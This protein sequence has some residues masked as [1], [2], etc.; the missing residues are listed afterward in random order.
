MSKFKKKL[1][2]RILAYILSG[3]M[4]MSNMTA[5][6]TEAPADTREEYYEEVSEDSVPDTDDAET[7]ETAQVEANLTDDGE[8]DGEDSDTENPDKDSDT[9]NPDDKDSDMENPKPSSSANTEE[10]SNVSVSSDAPENTSSEASEDKETPDAD[11]FYNGLEAKTF[12]EG[13]PYYFDFTELSD[14][15]NSYT[16]GLFSFN[17]GS[18]NGATYENTIYGV[19]FK[20]GNKLTFPISGDSYLVVGG[21]NSNDCTDLAATSTPG[22]VTPETLTTI[23]ANHGTLKNCKERGDNTLVFEYSG[24]T[25]TITLT[26]DPT[27]QRTTETE[28]NHPSQ[29]EYIAYV[30]IIPKDYEKPGDKESTEMNQSETETETGSDVSS[31]SAS[32]ESQPETETGTD[33]SSESAPSGS[34]PESE[35]ETETGTDKSSESASSES[36]P[37]SESETETGTDKSS[38]SVPMESETESEVETGSDE[39]SENAPSESQTDPTPITYPVTYDFRDGSI[40]PADTSLNGTDTVKS[41][42]GALTVECGPS[43]GYGYN[44]SDHGSILKEGN[45]ITLH[46]PGSVK[47]FI[48]GCQYSGGSLVVTNGS[49]TVQTFT[50]SKTEACYHNDS[51]AGL[52]FEYEGEETDLVM[53]FGAGSTYVPVITVDKLPDPI[54]YPVTY[55]FRDGSI[56]PADTSLNGTDTVKSADGALTVECGPSNGYGYNGSEHGSILKE[57]NKIT[58]HVP[59][60]VKVFIGGCQYSGGSLVVT[61]GSETV[62]TFTTSKTEACYHNDSTAGLSFE[63]KGEETDLVMTFGAGSTY[64]P[65]I[66]VDRISGDEN[67]DDESSVSNESESTTETATTPETS[68]TKNSSDVTDLEEESLP[69]EEDAEDVK[70]KA[71][72]TAE[73]GIVYLNDIRKIKVEA[74]DLVVGSKPAYRVTVTYTNAN[75]KSQELTEGIHYT[76]ALSKNSPTNDTTGKTAGDYRIT[77]T[78]TDTKTDLGIFKGTKTVSYKMI[79]KKTV[80]KTKDITKVKGIGFEKDATKNLTY[81]GTYVT[82]AI[83]VPGLTEGTHY[84]VVYKNNVNAGKA[85]ATVIGKGEYYGQKEFKFT[86][87]P[88]NIAAKDV[89]MILEASNAAIS[90]GAKTYEATEKTQTSTALTYKGKAITLN[91]LTVKLPKEVIKTDKDLTLK[92]GIDYTVTY[93]KNTTAGTATAAIKG[94]NNFSGAINVNYTIKAE[95]ITAEQIM[96]ATVTAE[97]TTKGAVV[98]TITLEGGLTLKAGTDFKADNKGLKDTAVGETGKAV[99][100]GNGAYKK[101]FDKVEVSATVERGSFHIK[102]NAVVDITKGE[103]S[104]KLVAA[105]KITDASGAKVKATDVTVAK[106]GNTAIKVTPTSA[107]AAKFNETTLTCHV[108]KKLSSVAKAKKIDKNNS[109]AIQKFDGV[110]NVTLTTDQIVKIYLDANGVNADDIRI[111]SYK[112]NNKIGA[113]TVV[114]EGRNNSPYYGTMNVKFTIA[115]AKPTLGTGA[116]DAGT[117]ESFNYEEESSQV[118]ES[119]GTDGSDENPGTGETD[120][121]VDGVVKNAGGKPDVWDFAAGAVKVDGSG[122]PTEYIDTEKYNNMLTEDVINS[123]NIT[124]GINPGSSGGAIGSFDVKDKDGNVI[125]EFNGNGKTNNRLRTMNKKITRHDEKSLKDEN[126][127]EYLGYVYS[128]SSSEPNVYLGVMLDEGDI[129]TAI[130]GSN[131]GASTIKFEP[132]DGG[133]EAQTYEYKAENERIATFYAATTGEYKMYS[134]NEKLVVA[135]VTVEKTNAVTVSGAVQ[136]PASLT[137]AYAVAFKCRETGAV[138]TA[139]VEDGKYTVSLNEGYTYDVALENANGYIIT[140]ETPNFKLEMGKDT[141][142]YDINITNVSLVTVTGSV[143]GFS[144]VA[145]G[146]QNPIETLDLTFASDNIYVP[147][148]TLN[149][150]TGEFTLVLEKGVEYVVTADGVDDFTLKTEKI[151]ADADGTQDITFEAKSVYNVTIKPEGVTAQD[152]AD[153]TFIFARLHITD[154]LKEYEEDYVYTFKGTEDIKLRDGQYEI[155]VGSDCPYEQKLTS[156]LKVDGADVEKTVKF[157]ADPVT[158]W[159]FSAAEGF[160]E[161]TLENFKGLLMNNVKN[162]NGKAHATSGAGGEYKVP[163]TGP[164][165]VTASYYYR[166]AGSM[167]DENPVEISLTE[168]VDAAYNSTSVVKDTTYTYTGNAGYVT[169]KT[170][171]TTYFTKITVEYADDKVEYKNTI[172]VGAENCDYKT[173]NDALN[174]VRN[175]ERTNSQRVTIEIQPGD[176]EEMLVVDTPNVTLKNANAN[177]SIMPIDKG[178]NIEDSSVRITSYYGHGYAYYSMGSDCKWDADIL[179]ANKENECLSFENPGTGTTSGS[180]WN[181]TVVI[182]ANGFEAEGIIFENSFNQYVSKKAADD[183]IVKLAGAKEGSTPRAEMQAGSTTVQDKKYVERA[184]ALAIKDACKNISFDNCSFIGRQDT[185]YGGTSVTAA[186]YDCDIYGGTDYIFGAMTAVFAKCNLVFNT[187][188]DGNDV[189]YITAAQTKSGRGYLMYNC[190]VTSTKPGVNTASEK[191]SKPGL[192]GRPW[193]ANTGEALFYKTIIE[194]TN[195]NGKEESLIQAAGWNSGLGGESVLSQEYAS[196]ELADGVDN[197]EKRVSWSSVLKADADGKVTLADGNTVVTDDTVVAAFLGEWKPFAGKD[198]TISNGQ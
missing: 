104:A 56:I 9:E 16:K 50:T 107:T 111:V 138:K 166:A 180:Y 146:N 167:G 72:P 183:I 96:K 168:G 67:P 158:N 18:Y 76:A 117:D 152:L 11:G 75:G 136:A 2:G 79:D 103:D 143:K 191:T 58:L 145:G 122:M 172:T 140:N 137:G 175:M 57:G 23:T 7:E 139:A 170:T 125:F 144:A 99:V 124:S 193:Q 101:M 127:V 34:Q 87:K 160:T 61:N 150:E 36:Q 4:L 164:C 40:I 155:K 37:E 59:G 118:P 65:V 151:S 109:D 134:T 19:T 142:T 47:V 24:E 12:V 80:D 39:S 6:A 178:V 110:N 26:V 123:W 108:A 8:T 94:M 46:V 163:V 196:I 17:A 51:T 195:F 85:S 181:A 130:V 42:D 119:N 93:K 154:N 176:Y 182:D 98:S 92:P 33:K 52:S 5:F 3:A 189:G 64:V 120:T 82:P 71:D 89:T 63:Y 83:T 88:A 49:E 185:L 25:G 60:S 149:K 116:E 188:E 54:I 90:K 156:D 131:G 100:T 141:F 179:A 91:G 73:D 68:E 129:V 1:G 161:E 198:M 74:A 20:S 10:T 128:N 69:E 77:V 112:N 55:D 44:G 114:I 28:E 186:F 30:C 32:N 95:T 22:T 115:A 153:T 38:E 162:E 184:A 173:I 41:A 133:V 113:A 86:I 84:T 62:Q 171:A 29:K 31:E 135:R 174:A 159:T 177:P 66:I 147:Q 105:A 53:T 15:A 21:D 97:A 81:T 197:S 165:T 14:I 78:G 187:M 106:V 13:R 126:G 192:L 169:I 132:V 27:Y 190:T 45:K 35:S 157:S 194:T 48:G 148:L 43:N 102:D 70:I 121:E